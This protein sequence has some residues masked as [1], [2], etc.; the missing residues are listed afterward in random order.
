MKQFPKAQRRKRSGE[1]WQVVYIDLMT[2]V[3]VFFVILWSINQGR[4]VKLSERTGDHT[5]RM[6]TL[7]GDVI[8]Y[9]GKTN[10]TGEGADVFKK[11]FSSES[12]GEALNF[13]TGP[14]TKRFLVIH[15]HTDSD[16]VKDDNFDL[17]YGRALAAYHE[18]L[19]YSKDIP[20]HVVLCTHADNTPVQEIP[21][22][23][24]QLTQPQV[25]ALRVMKAKNRRITIEDRMESRVQ[26]E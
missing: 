16:G 11:L 21:A 14:A 9:P 25:D 17:G 15:G 3:M 8:F 24:G 6:L 22:I 13:S 12:T 18:I 23:H 2:N 4:P 1:G 19:K 5:S 26:T 10:V 20:D 7:P